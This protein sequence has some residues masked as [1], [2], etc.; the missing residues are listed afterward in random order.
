MGIGPEMHVVGVVVRGERE[1]TMVA[2][3]SKPNQ[4]IPLKVVGWLRVLKNWPLETEMGYCTKKHAK[5][6]SSGTELGSF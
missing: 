5:R 2:L 3:V 1:P 6:L 4:L